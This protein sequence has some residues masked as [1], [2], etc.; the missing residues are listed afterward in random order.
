M[1]QTEQYT[2]F[3]GKQD[4]FSNWHPCTFEYKGVRFNC[5]EQFMMY[6]KAMLFGDREVAAR[7]LA[8]SDPKTQKALGRQVRGF[9]E[10]VWTDK[11]MS[12]VTVGCREKFR[13]SPQL[14]EGLLA[15]GTRQLVEASPY[16]KIWGIGLS[17]DDPRAEHPDKWLGKNLLGQ[18]LMQAR[19]VLLARRQA[20]DQNAAE[21]PTIGSTFGGRSM[22]IRR[23]GRQAVPD[24]EPASGMRP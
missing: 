4:I 1:R 11:C 18:A 20:E 5:V 17:E 14:L 13:Q 23:V 3:F 10:V 15:T 8:T 9:D 21:T 19:A 7:I 2:F 24:D 16:D 6:S 22:I 12:I